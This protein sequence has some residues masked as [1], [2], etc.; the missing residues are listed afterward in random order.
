M[1]MR[2]VI[3]AITGPWMVVG[4]SV[5]VA[6]VILALFLRWKVEPGWLDRLGRLLGAMAIGNAVLGWMVYRI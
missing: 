4:G 2:D 3:D 6:W 1:L 5:V